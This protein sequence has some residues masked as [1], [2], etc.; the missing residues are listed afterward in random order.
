[1]AHA[2][3]L[4]QTLERLG[5][6]SFIQLTAIEYRVFSIICRTLG[7]TPYGMNCFRSKKNL[8]KE[9]DCS[10]RSI[11]YAVQKLERLN[12]I[13]IINTKR[14]KN[15]NYQIHPAVEQTINN[16]EDKVIHNQCSSCTSLDCTSVIFALPLCNPC[17]TLV[18]QLHP[19]LN[20]TINNTIN[21]IYNICIEKNTTDYQQDQKENNMRL[22]LGTQE[23]RG[24]LPWGGGQKLYGNRTY[25][26]K[27]TGDYCYNHQ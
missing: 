10:L 4:F 20:K 9:C 2:H 14:G 12:L 5:V 7:S 18:Q 22:N 24:Y 11:H 27:V 3:I 23:K 25:G 19:R 16:L 21:N 26:Q 17:T 6:I 13:K 1:M 15:N 8:S